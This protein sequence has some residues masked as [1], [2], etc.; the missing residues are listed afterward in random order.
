MPLVNPAFRAYGNINPSSF[1]SIYGSADF[2]VQAAGA[3]VRTFGIAQDG[4]KYPQTADGWG[5]GAVTYAAEDGDQLA[6]FG[7]GEVCLLDVDNSGTAAAPAISPGDYLIAKSN[8][9]GIKWTTT[10]TGGNTADTP[11][12]IGAIALEAPIAS[13]ASSLIRVQVVCFSHTP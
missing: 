11:S 6:V 2:T 12:L 3:G 9:Q 5:S 1:V 7:L 4:S 10:A 13:S 8:G